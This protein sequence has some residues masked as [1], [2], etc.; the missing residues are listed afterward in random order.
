ML[1]GNPKQLPSNHWEQNILNSSLCEFV[2]FIC[3]IYWEYDFSRDAKY[4][5]LKRCQS[6]FL[7]K[8]LKLFLLKGIERNLGFM[9][10]SYKFVSTSLYLTLQFI[11]S[12]NY[13]YSTIR[14]QVPFKSLLPFLRPIVPTVEWYRRVSGL[15]RALIHKK[16]R[17]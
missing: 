15:P 7:V 5:F 3:S 8:A 12:L 1:Y 6:S 9:I 13:L 4:L 2:S 14:V 11:L 16:I 17:I 10:N